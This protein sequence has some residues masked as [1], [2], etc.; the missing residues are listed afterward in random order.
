[1]VPDLCGLHDAS[2]NNTS[3]FTLLLRCPGHV[4]ATRKHLLVQALNL[5]K[6]IMGLCQTILLKN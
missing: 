2:S 5:K 3:V 6:R 4:L 1:M